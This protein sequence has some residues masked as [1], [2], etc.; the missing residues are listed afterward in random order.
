MN[1]IVNAIA[2]RLS[3][4]QP[5]KYSLEILAHLCDILSLEKNADI[6]EALKAVQGEYA[7]VTDFERDFP[8]LCFAL[9]TGVGKT[10]LMGAFIAYLYKAV[11]LRHFFVLAPNLTIYNK[12]IADFTPNTPKYVF[13]GKSEFAMDPPEIITGD[14]YESGRGVRDDFSRQQRFGFKTDGPVH[15]N[16]FNISKINSEVRK[17]NAPRIKRLAEYIGQSYFEYLSGLDDLVLLMDESHRYRATAGV[18]AINELKPVLG[19]ELTATPQVEAGGKAVPF[20]NVIYS[21]PLSSAMT[22]GYVKEPAVATRENFDAKS[23]DADSL[24]RLKLEDGVRIHENTKVE[25]EVYARENGKPIVKPFMLV[26]ARDT[27]HANELVKTIEDESFFEGRYKGKV[28]QVHSKQSGEERDETVQQLI[29]VEKPENPTEIVIHVNMLKEGWDVTN[30]YTIVPLRAANSQTLVEQAIGR[31]LRLPYRKRTGVGAVDRLTIVAHDKFQDIID[32]ANSPESVIRGGLKVV[33]VN[34]ERSKVYVA[35][36]EI[37]YRVRP[38]EV[39]GKPAAPAIKQKPL[40]ES[41]R[42]FEAAKATL[43][44]IRCEYEKLSRSADL[45]RPEIQK[46]IVEKVQEIIAPA[47]DELEGVA[48]KMD[49]VKVVAETITMHNELLIDIPRITIQP[50]GDVTRGYKEFKLDLSSV[51]LQPV[52]NEILIQELHQREQVLLMSGTGIM[53]EDKPEDY[54][55]RGLMEFDDISYDEHAGLLYNLAG[56]VVMHLRT[57]LKDE[58]E[59][60]NVL[61]YHKPA[62]VNVVHAQ[63]QDHYEDKAEG[64]EVHVSK[65]FTTLRANNYS[66]PAGETERDFRVPVTDKQD[67]RR[68]L[69]AGFEKCLYRVQKF[70]SDTERRFAAILEKDKDVLKWFK[71]GRGDFRIHYAGDAS[72]EPDFIVETSDMK[73]ICEPKAAGEMTDKDVLA[74]ARAAVEWCA[75]ATFHELKHGGKPWEYLLIPHDAI[76]ENKTLKGL[77]ASFTVK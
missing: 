73:Y 23:Y 74:K 46:E 34:D 3:L 43:E 56:Q 72:Y 54:I 62:L 26:I 45:A 2:N 31:G 75:H 20:K 51:R 40:F 50:V 63:M 77:A 70:D 12:L 38:S 52:E 39:S 4:R 18:R 33:Y 17:G 36:P 37:M 11:G 47:Q 65:G 22:D 61:Q 69:F 49:V 71:P 29:N 53:P 44:I 67:I 5:Q 19:L 32:Y 60:L 25:L 6:T 8:S 57:Y 21:Y 35:E 58:D 15:I 64:Y 24:E 13:Q 59:V 55:V 9:A 42:E 27:G 66:A 68:M 7:S 76:S 10:R 1:P 30:L 14:N 41:S 28:I 16:I 48:E